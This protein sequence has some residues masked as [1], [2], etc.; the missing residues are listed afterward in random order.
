MNE[1]LVSIEAPHFVAGAVLIGDKAVRAA[2]IISYMYGW[3]LNRVQTYANK[4]RWD[5]RVV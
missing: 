4:K 2:P 5:A 1:Q 3:T